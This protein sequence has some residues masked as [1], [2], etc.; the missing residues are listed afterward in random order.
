MKCNETSKYYFAFSPYSSMF[1]L[2]RSNPSTYAVIQALL[3]IV[4]FRFETLISAI[5]DSKETVQLKYYSLLEI[6]W[7]MINNA[8]I[9]TIDMKNCPRFI[10]FFD[11]IT[12]Y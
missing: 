1:E 8:N 5:C 3:L 10:Y 12:K 11:L 6:S 9:F 2:A 4:G 7:N